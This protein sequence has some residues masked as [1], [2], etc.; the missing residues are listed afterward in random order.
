VVNV[1]SSKVL[2]IFSGGKTN[3]CRESNIGSSGSIWM[4]IS[5]RLVSIGSQSSSPNSGGGNNSVWESRSGS[6]WETCFMDE[7]SSLNPG[8]GDRI[9]EKDSSLLKTKLS[10]SW[11][12]EQPRISS[13]SQR[14]VV[15]A[16]SW[17]GGGELGGI[18]IGTTSL[19]QVDRDT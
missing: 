12:L 4:E 10:E 11:R 1:S 19:V 6:P 16:D 8:G 9:S 13:L 18:S 5:K 17:D 15:S 14:D 7:S 3:S 2:F